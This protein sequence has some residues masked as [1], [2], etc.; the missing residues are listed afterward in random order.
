MERTHS[1][2]LSPFFDNW[3]DV[4]A[5]IEYKGPTPTHVVFTYLE[6][7]QLRGGAIAIGPDFDINQ[8]Y[9]GL[10]AWTGRYE[11]ATNRL[12]AVQISN[13]GPWH[14]FDSLNT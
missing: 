14:S 2:E 12:V 13:A 4:Q 8:I 11:T 5:R 3:L 1:R 9:G 10:M 7:D 6:K